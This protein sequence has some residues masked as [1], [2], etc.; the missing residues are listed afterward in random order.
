MELV[1][2]EEFERERVKLLQQISD[3]RAAAGQDLKIHDM[4]HFLINCVMHFGH[5]VTSR[6][7]VMGYLKH[8]GIEVRPAGIYK[9]GQIVKNHKV[10]FHRIFQD[11]KA[12]K[13]ETGIKDMVS[14]EDIALEFEGLYEDEWTRKC[15]SLQR[16]L[17]PNPS[18]ERFKR[19]I[20][21]YVEALCGVIQ[22]DAQSVERRRYMA[23]MG[24]FLWQVQ[25]KLHYGPESI[26]RQGNEAMLLLYSRAQKTGKSTAVRHLLSTFLDNGLVWKADFERLADPFSLHNLVYNY[27]SWFDDAGRSSIK[28]MEKF[29]QMVTESEVS[30]RAMYTQTEMKLPKFS[31]LIGTSNKHAKELMH[32]T[33]GLRRFHQIEVNSGKVHDGTGIDLDFISQFDHE[34]LIRSCPI[35]EKKSPLLLFLSEKELDDYEEAM[36]PR[37]VVELWA[38][39]EGYKPSETADGGV[40]PVQDMYDSLLKWC[41]DN[42]YRGQYVPTSESFKNKLTELGYKKGRTAR[43]RGFYVAD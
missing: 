6:D 37:H 2:S 35:G 20:E 42:G 30:F 5:H 11:W 8:H 24:H 17:K 26:L 25:M 41:A 43:H 33:T 38:A 21:K 34:E 28:N 39:E 27:V 14:K 29:K 12:F 13:R 31:T 19:L 1:T 10:L 18:E 40:M 4:Y 3:I 7:F 22:P 15:T 9:N 23:F 16:A 36:R 32:D